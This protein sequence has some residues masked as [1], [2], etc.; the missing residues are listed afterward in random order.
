MKKRGKK[1]FWSG[2]SILLISLVL[3]LG[4]IEDGRA[5]VQAA[6]QKSKKI[7]SEQEAIE[8]AK[9]WITIPLGYEFRWGEYV[10]PYGALRTPNGAWFLHFFHSDESS[11]MYK[12]H[13][14]SGQLE[15][16]AYHTNKSVTNRPTTTNREKIA[17]DAAL[18]F[19]TKV[20]PSEE[21]AKLTARKEG[22]YESDGSEPY[23]FGFQ[24]VENGFPLKNNLIGVTVAGDGKVLNF[25]RLWYEGE[26]PDTSQV[27]SEKKARELLEQKTEPTM[28]YKSISSG[29]GE[30][31][32][33]LVYDYLPTDPQLVDAISGEMIDGKGALAKPRKPIKSL[34]E[35]PLI[36]APKEGSGVNGMLTREQA[37]ASAIHFLQTKRRDQLAD[38][39][40]LDS[41]PR[42]G[43]M[44]DWGK[45]W[46][47]YQVYF[48]W[49]KNGIQI[50]DEPFIIHV[51]A[52]TGYSSTAG[53]QIHPPVIVDN[54]MQRVDMA[55][56]KKTEQAVKK[57]LNLYYFLP[58]NDE[59]GGE[60]SKARLVYSICGDAGVVDAHTG[61]WISYP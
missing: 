56:A 17:S 45:Y 28:Y 23:F 54:N 3:V 29:D 19:L 48:G 13:P 42:D 27:I 33:M 1:V 61:K 57:S 36:P 15:G 35:M 32:Y 46:W 41:Q 8:F 20:I 25:Y 7:L 9:K 24:R 55:F 12:I 18:Q 51:N 39:Y 58:V 14:V 59:N 31:K 4:N 38:I 50:K 22:M 44:S 11:I 21:R 47:D 43:D 10:E 52:K 40:M 30:S 34:K 2:S 26:L 16:Y 5:L 37:E 49:L 6:E 53:Q 60:E